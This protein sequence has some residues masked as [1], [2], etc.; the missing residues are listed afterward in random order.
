MA[1]EAEVNTGDKCRKKTGDTALLYVC[2][3]YESPS[4]L[5]ALKASMVISPRGDCGRSKS[6][7]YHV[8]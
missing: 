4:V 6:F 5:L 8:K 7:S 1:A 3:G 2:D